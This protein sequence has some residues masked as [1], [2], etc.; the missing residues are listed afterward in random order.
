M[1]FATRTIMASLVVLMALTGCEK[2]DGGGTTVIVEPTVLDCNYFQEDRILEDNPDAPV[3]YIVP[4][5]ATVS[6]D[7]VVMP[8]VV[9]EFEDDAGLKV[10]SGT[11]KAEGTAANPIVF[12]GVNKIKGSWRGIYISTKSVNN[13]LDHVTISYGGGNAFSSNDNRGNLILY[14]GK[15]SMTNTTLSYSADFGFNSPFRDSEI[16][17]FTS[18]T[19]TENDDYPVYAAGK[20]GYVFDGSND[21]TGNASGKNYIYVY[22]GH[23]IGDNHVWE[24]TTVPYRVDGE[25]WVGDD[26]SLTIDPGAELRFDDNSGIKIL[27]GGYIDIN[28]TAAEPVL[29]SGITEVNDSWKGMIIDSEDVRN[30]IEYAI[31]EYGGGSAFN[32]NGDLGLIIIWAD[33][34]LSISNSTLQHTSACAITAEYNGETLVNLNNTFNDVGAEEC[35]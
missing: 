24:K 10:N 4:C 15:L 23:S 25:I 16:R 21:F 11:L 9:I 1:K 31:I 13:I 22:G 32:S 30:V 17:A 28:G 27:D 19:I 18:N 14:N 2:E 5:V 34:Y 20:Y 8:G 12:T 35:Q 29:L 3:D 7:I 26:Q 33:S 6:G